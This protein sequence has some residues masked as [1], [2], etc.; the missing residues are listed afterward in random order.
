MVSLPHSGTAHL[1]IGRLAAKLNLHHNHRR[2]DE[3][4]GVPMHFVR[5]PL[6]VDDSGT[7]SS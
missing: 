7:A 6:V 2:L 3:G 4:A 5:R 1:L